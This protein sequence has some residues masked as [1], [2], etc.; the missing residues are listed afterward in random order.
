M[1]ITALYRKVAWRLLPLVFFIYLIAY[2]DRANI[3]FAKLRMASA[4]GFSDA[5]FGLGI[6]VFFLGYLFLQIPGAVMVERGSARKWFAWILISWGLISALTAF[7][8]TPA[9]FYVA[10]FALG[11]AEAGFFPGV[12]V[13]LTHWFVPEYRTRVFS[14]LIMAAPVSLALGAPLSALLLRVNWLGLAGW[15]WLFLV[16]GLPAV[17]LGFFT[18]W[19]ITD[20]PGNAQWLT[21]AERDNLETAL[22]WEA[23]AKSG[24]RM[25][26]RQVLCLPN[27][28]LLALGIFVTNIGG[29]AIVFWLPSILKSLAGNSDQ[30]A[31]YYSGLFY[32]C[33]ILGLLAAGFSSDRSGDRKWH[34]VGGL[35]G[36]GLLL[37]LSGMQGQ[38]FGVTMMWLCLTAVAAFFWGAPFWTLP[39]LTLSTPAAAV[40]V[41]FISM[42]A[43]FS[44]YIG[45]HAIGW[46]RDRGFGDGACL[47]SFAGC[48]AIGGLLVAAVKLPEKASRAV[49]H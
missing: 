11:L 26:V 27:V 6:G 20:R 46:L 8:R 48:Y 1:Q 2:L 45:N 35:L 15:Q 22:A 19:W 28:W 32:V 17:A 16:E 13:Y 44:G 43:N 4:L 49:P 34:C 24:A 10:R 36:T 33:G 39:T 18:L 9:Q 42:A 3:G 23:T 21:Q 47:W 14:V 30:A 12:V 7:V 29:Y 31:L 5:V 25:T 38:S 41:G 37:G 40:A